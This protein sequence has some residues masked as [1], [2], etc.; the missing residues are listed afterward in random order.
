[1]ERYESFGECV[2]RC[3]A[4]ADLSASEAARL[5]GFKSRNSIFRILSGDTSWEINLRFLSS[6]HDAVGKEWPEARWLSL[7]EAL[8][9]ERLGPERYRANRAFHRVLHEPEGEIPSYLVDHAE[10]DGALHER[11]L[12]AVLEEILQAERVEIIITGCCENGLSRLLREC[13]D[14][15][16]SQGTLSVRH[17]IDTAEDQVTQNILGILP[18]I[19]KPWYNARLVDPASCPPEMMAIYR[20]HALHIHQWDAQGHQYGQ[21]FIRYDREHFASYARTLGP[22]PP[23]A[24]LDRWRF[25]LELL[26]PMP[27]LSSGAEAFVEYT[28]QYARLEDNCTILSIKPDVHFNCI[29]PT[30]LAAAVT[31]GFEQAGFAGGEELQAL[32]ATLWEIHEGRYIN[33]TAKRKPTHLVYSLPAMKRFMQTGV[34]TDQFFIQRAYTVEERRAIIRVLLE[35]MRQQPYFNVH[36]FKQD[37]PALCY[38]ISYYDGKGVLLMD[39]YTGYELGAD[40]SEALITLPAFMESFRRYFMDELLVNYVMSRADSLRELEQLLVMKVQE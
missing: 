6:L 39:A 20:T 31:E 26:K 2:K 27:N 29:P 40:H 33:T 25:H 24:V 10:G 37:S 7:Q 14:A 22:C 36:F 3:L 28:D 19:S 32:I 23:V 12:Q 13:C 1:M 8:S 15:A 21:T 38:E 9:V 11:S 17:Y 5:V 4:E 18:L 35:A 16:G 34:L 30:V